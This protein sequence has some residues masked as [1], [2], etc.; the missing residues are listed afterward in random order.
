MPSKITRKRVDRKSAFYGILR[1]DAAK[2]CSE[3]ADL[4]AALAW[5]TPIQFLLA[6][7]AARVHL[8]GPLPWTQVPQHQYINNLPPGKTPGGK[9]VT[10]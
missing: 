4:R 10:I 3:M 6:V 9:Q 5:K 1:A 2:N 7:N 8:A